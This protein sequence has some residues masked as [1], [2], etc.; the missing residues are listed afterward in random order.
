MVRLPTATHSFDVDEGRPT[1]LESKFPGHG[2]AG[3]NGGRIRTVDRPA[4]EAHRH[5]LVGPSSTPD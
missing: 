2:D 5:C 3:M 1:A 4:W